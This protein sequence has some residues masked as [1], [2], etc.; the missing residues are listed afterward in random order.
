MRYSTLITILTA[1]AA[2]TALPAA[3]EVTSRDMEAPIGRSAETVIEPGGVMVDGLSAVQSE[4][5]N[6]RMDTL[7]SREDSAE[8]NE[9]GVEPT[10]GTS[11]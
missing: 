8:V 11:D 2:A 9:W 10:T 1:A 5:H 7:G 6:P 3:A 4:D